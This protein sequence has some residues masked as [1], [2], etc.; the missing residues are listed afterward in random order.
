M[1]GID[2]VENSEWLESFSRSLS[3][4]I[5]FNLYNTLDNDKQIKEFWDKCSSFYHLSCFP[6]DET[7]KQWEIVPDIYEIL[8]CFIH[9]ANGH[10]LDVLICKYN[11]GSIQEANNKVELLK[12]EYEKLWI[13]IKNPYPYVYMV[14]FFGGSAWRTAQYMIWELKNKFPEKF[15]ELKIK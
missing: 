2:L 5:T 6:F 8:R 14:G 4:D 13:E 11:E 15:K 7:I 12:K 10:P 1:E 3:S 9:T